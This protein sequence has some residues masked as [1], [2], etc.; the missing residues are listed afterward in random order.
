MIDSGDIDVYL[1]LDVGEGEHHATALTSSGKRVLGKRLP[2]TEPRLVH[3]SAPQ[4]M[5]GF[6]GASSPLLE[7]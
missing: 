7:R 5:H 4:Q 6:P 1:S 3:N 2:N